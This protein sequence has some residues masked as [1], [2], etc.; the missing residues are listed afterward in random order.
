MQ[1]PNLPTDN[2][3]KFMAM[4]GMAIIIMGF[5]TV[6][7]HANRSQELFRELQQGLALSN[8][9]LEQAMQIANP[10]ERLSLLRKHNLELAKL[11]SIQKELEFILDWKLRYEVFAVACMVLGTLL[12]GSGFWLWYVRVQRHLDK[13]LHDKT[14]DA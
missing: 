11:T 7:A 13:M 2:L 9:E 10:E 12:S 5:L 3:Y 6:W 14:L 8:T 4:A 1:I